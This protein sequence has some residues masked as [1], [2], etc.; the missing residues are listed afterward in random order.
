MHPDLGVDRH[1]LVVDPRRADAIG[2]DVAGRCSLCLGRPALRSA[3]GEELLGVVALDAVEQLL[4]FQRRVAEVDQAVAGQ[5]AGVAF[6]GREPG[7][8][9]SSSAPATFS[10]SSTMIRSE[11]R[12]PIP[13]T[14]WKRF[15]SPAAIARSSSRAVPPERVAIATLGPIPLTEISTRKR[16]RSSSEAKP[17]RAS[18]SSR[19]ISS[20]CRK[21]SRA[22]RGDRFQRLRGDRQPIADAGGVDHDVVG[23]A[24]HHLAADR[25]DHPATRSRGAGAPHR[26]RPR[27]AAR[28]LP[29]WQIATASASAAWSG[30]GGSGSPSSVPTIR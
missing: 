4:G 3:A 27:C 8:D 25:G 14:A 30:V 10:R 24:D 13:G 16:S 20:A 19:E 5:G 23:A 15:A 18:E 17:K 2:A 22:G 26:P 6:L 28:R 21:A 7:A 29:P 9:C 1:R 12:L 11:V